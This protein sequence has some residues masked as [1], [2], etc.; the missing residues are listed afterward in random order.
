VSTGD[1]TLNHSAKRSSTLLKKTGKAC[2]A[3]RAGIKT[4]FFMNNLMNNELK[5]YADYGGK[6]LKGKPE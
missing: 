4:Y 5:Q 1:Y 3:V 2:K 6:I